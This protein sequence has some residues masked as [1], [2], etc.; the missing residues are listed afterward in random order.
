MPRIASV[1]QSRRWL[2]LWIHSSAS[3]NWWHWSKLCTL[4]HLW[5]TIFYKRI[6]HSAKKKEPK[7]YENDNLNKTKK[8]RYG[9]VDPRK[10]KS[11]LIKY[12]NCKP[13]TS[14][15]LHQIAQERYWKL[16]VYQRQRPRLSLCF[17]THTIYT[18][19]P[20]AMAGLLQ[21]TFLVV[22]GDQLCWQHYALQKIRTLEPS[23]PE[24]SSQKNFYFPY[25]PRPTPFRQR[26]CKYP[27]SVEVLFFLESVP[28]AVN[29]LSGGI[30][31]STARTPLWS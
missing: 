13:N 20:F 27:I 7:T 22:I 21:I 1:P 24:F 29:V 3:Q 17:P 26:M 19:P 31:V 18:P 2:P 15:I 8:S 10:R 25:S 16:R 12:C 14:I 11:G 23:S 4:C 30:L 5:E 6:F 9:N 28:E